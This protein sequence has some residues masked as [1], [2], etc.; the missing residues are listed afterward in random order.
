MLTEAFTRF[1]VKRHEVYLAKNAGQPK[2]WTKDPI[3]QQFRFCNVYRELDTVT[4][5]IAR[6]WR[7]PYVGHRNHTAA[8]VFA[9][10]VNWPDTLGDIGFPLRWGP[11]RLK[12]IIRARQET[13]QKTWSAAYIVSTCGRAM[14]KEEYVVDLVCAEVLRCRDFDWRSLANAHRS[15]SRV[16]GLGSFMAA[17]V[18]ADLKNTPG[19]PLNRAPDWYEWCAPGP[20]SLR[21][22]NRLLGNGAVRTAL[23]PDPFRA[24]VRKLAEATNAVIEPLG[25]APLCAQDVQNCLCEFDKYERVRLLEGKPRQQYPGR[26]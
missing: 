12:S 19:H 18:V 15:L 20:G 2:P 9:R 7:N 5:W 25:W 10:M 6:N 8:V 1:V 16:D 4:Q 26:A 13:G 23:P 21:G 22:L 17:Q 11:D 3:L 24:H 14:P